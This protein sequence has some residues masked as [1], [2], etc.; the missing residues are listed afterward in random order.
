MIRGVL[1]KLAKNVIKQLGYD[2]NKTLEL[3]EL[4]DEFKNI[5]NYGINGG[6]GGFIYYSDTAKF[7][8]DN[9]DLI[10]ELLNNQAQDFGYKNELEMLENFN[11]LK[12]E[13]ITLK[14]INEICNFKGESENNFT[15]TNIK[16]ALSWYAGEEVAHNA[17]N[18][19]ENKDIDKKY[20]DSASNKLN[21]Y[22][23]NAIKNI[24]KENKQENTRNNR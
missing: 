1:A 15:H 2:K 16:N 7:F 5:S 17:N 10:L 24:K 3:L 23:N 11:C 9:K 6:Y 18:I 12:G 4:S 22:I 8:D 20:L 14:D 19:L 21:N 13:T